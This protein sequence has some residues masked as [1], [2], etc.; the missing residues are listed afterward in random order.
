MG[1]IKGAQR[2]TVHFGEHRYPH[3]AL[4]ATRVRRNGFTLVELIVGL[5]I[6]GLLLASG[7]PMFGDWLDA[8]HL[9]N[10]AK[11]L[12]ESM[13]RARTEAIRRGARVNLCK[14]ADGRRCVDLG[15]WDVGFLTYVDI[16]RDGAMAHGELVLQSDGPAPAGITV[17]ANRP[18]EDY[19]SYTS[20]GHARMRNG[21][22]QMGTLTVCKRGQRALDIVL[23]SSGRVRIEKSRDRCP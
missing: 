15:G 16:N 19:I 20:L 6:A 1:G 3:H 7:A 9:A 12:A 13:T 5:A 21:A 18:V 22:L 4:D 17:R 14:S 2:S 23:A 11:H 8:Y 10:H